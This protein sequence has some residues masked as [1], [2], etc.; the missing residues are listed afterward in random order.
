V[1]RYLELARRTIGTHRADVQSPAESDDISNQ[2]CR[3]ESNE[4][5]ERSL[6]A[7]SVDDAPQRH[8]KTVAAW[9]AGVARLAAM[10][11]HPNYPQHAWQQLVVDAERLLDDWAAQAAAL[12][13]QDWEIFGCHRRAPFGRIDGMGLVLLLRGRGL[14]ALTATEAVIRA[15]TGA[16]QTYRRRPCDPLHPAERCLVWELP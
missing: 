2:H 9:A 8:M 16:R 5:N 15:R 7:T 3:Y 1:G 10:A 14:A 13:W 12:G 11:S 4:K 6:S